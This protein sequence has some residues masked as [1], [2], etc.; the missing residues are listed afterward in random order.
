MDR[1]LPNFVCAL[2]LT[3]S[4][5]G[6]LTFI[7]RIFVNELWPLI[8]FRISFLSIYLEQMD[9]IPSNFVYALI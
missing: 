7:F 4:S 6:L 9:R 2:I 1:I 8:D 5:L 3:R